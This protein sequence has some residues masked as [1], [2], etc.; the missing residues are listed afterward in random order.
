M[1]REQIGILVK[2]NDVASY[3]ALRP[4]PW[5]KIR[6]AINGIKELSKELMDA[7]IA[8]HGDVVLRDIF[9]SGCFFN[10]MYKI[11]LVLPRLSSDVDLKFYYRN[12][13]SLQRVKDI[14]FCLSLSSF[15][16]VELRVFYGHFFIELCNYRDPEKL[17][18]FLNYYE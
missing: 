17:V 10:D 16:L 12:M 9:C 3:N 7:L 11:K 6:H 2:N 15:K 8:D 13:L 1:S 14:E 5:P 18:F 4:I